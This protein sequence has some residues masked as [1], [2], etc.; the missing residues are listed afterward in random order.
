[1]TTLRHPARLAAALACILVALAPS[2]GA[3]WGTG[4]HAS[5]TVTLQDACGFGLLDP[6]AQFNC[7]RVEG[8]IT[9]FTCAPGTDWSCT[10]ATYSVTVTAYNWINDGSFAGEL[11]GYVYCSATDTESASWTGALLTPSIPVTR[12][13]SISCPGW[14]QE[15]GDC[16]GQGTRYE[17]DYSGGDAPSDKSGFLE[18]DTGCNP[19]P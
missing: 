11:E 16:F 19:W 7:V 4:A 12:T 10:G 8:S 5:P 18:H 3:H 17:V 13:M 2:A 1:M 9:T 14:T 6:V 15:F